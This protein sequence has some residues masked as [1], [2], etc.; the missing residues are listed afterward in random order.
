MILLETD[1]MSPTRVAP[2]LHPYQQHLGVSPKLIFIGEK[3]R[4]TT[5]NIHSGLQDYAC[6]QR[7]TRKTQGTQHT[8]A[9]Q[10]LRGNDTGGAGRNPHTGFLRL[11]PAHEESHGAHTQSSA[12]K[13]QRV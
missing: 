7:F 13:T 2:C 11:S 4:K 3:S 8:R 5:L 12:M 6:D 10:S 1:N 9:A